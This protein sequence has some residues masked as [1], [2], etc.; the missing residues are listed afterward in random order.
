MRLRTIYLFPIILLFFSGCRSQRGQEKLRKYDLLA[1]DALAQVGTP[2]KFGGCEPGAFDCSG[3]VYYVYQKH[4]ITLPRTSKE[5]SKAGSSVS[6]RNVRK[7]DLLF[8]RGSNARKRKI[9]HVGIVI[10]DENEPVKFVHASSSRGV[11]VSQL[12]TKY[13]DI[14]FR[15]ARRFSQLKKKVK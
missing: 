3:L 11:V 8:F 12:S 6:I 2:Y 5:Q 7:G 4:G 13:Y 15:K 14:R 9:G 1:K 10:S